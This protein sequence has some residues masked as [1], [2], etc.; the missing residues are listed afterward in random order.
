MTEM[1]EQEAQEWRK[2]G[3]Q[4]TRA[5]SQISL[6]SPDGRVFSMLYSGEVDELAACLNAAKV[7]NADLKVEAIR[8]AHVHGQIVANYQSTIAAL[9]IDLNKAQQEVRELREDLARKDQAIA[10]MLATHL[11]FAEGERLRAQL[12]AAEARNNQLEA[13]FRAVDAVAQSKV[14]DWDVVGMYEKGDNELASVR[15]NLTTTTTLLQ[16]ARERSKSL[17]LMIRDMDLLATKESDG[18]W[19]TGYRWNTGAWHKL[20][21][22]IN[23]AEPLRPMRQVREQ[24]RLCSAG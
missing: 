9:R 7:A 8:V 22:V 3:W 10:D 24:I 16:Q 19:V 1:A 20:L 21:G 2:G 17:E 14:E 12:Q 5:L 18:E 4:P 23:G 6:L 15:A 11:S 13:D